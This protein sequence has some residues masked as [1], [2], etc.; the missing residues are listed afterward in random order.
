[1]TS[2]SF[3]LRDEREQRARYAAY[4]GQA[5]VGCVSWILVRKTVLL[6][7]IEVDPVKH[8]LGIGSLLTR[9]AFDDAR[10][11]GHSVLALCPYVRR[12]AQLHPAYRDIA[13]KPAAGELAALS[14]LLA[15]EKTM[16]LLHQDRDNTR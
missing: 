3:E 8:D 9:R 2:T 11:E 12:W 10:T 14:A 5:R 15:A 16:R 13:R 1:L 4:L 6:A 7:H